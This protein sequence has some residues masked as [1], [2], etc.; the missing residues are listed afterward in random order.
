MSDKKIILIDMHN[1]LVDE[2]KEYGPALDAA[3]DAFIAAARKNNSLPADFD[4]EKFKNDQ[5][6]PE[7]KAAHAALSD[8]WDN[9]AFDKEHA[10]ALRALFADD[11]AYEAAK[12]DAI[13]ARTE[14]SKNYISANAYPGAINFIKRARMDGH[15]VYVVTDGNAV[16]AEATLAWLGLD[17]E[18]DGVFCPPSDKAAYMGTPR[19]TQTPVVHFAPG[20]FKPD[21]SIV[22]DILLYHAKNIGLVPTTLSRDEAF[23]LEENTMLPAEASSSLKNR[24]NIK[25]GAHEPTI[26]HLLQNTIG[27]G[28]DYRDHILFQNAGVTSVAADYGKPAE[29]PETTR[30]KAIMKAVSGW[31]PERLDLL[32]AVGGKP[33]LEKAV[34]PDY[35][36]KE[37]LLEA[38]ILL[39]GMPAVK[40]AVGVAH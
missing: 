5:A 21:A 38:S 26:Q 13:H 4:A 15:T 27:I 32:G 2:V 24:L 35:R 14:F 37:S 7:L 1:T 40:A 25:S 33:W 23:A 6:Y 34:N 20:Q 30:G 39:T 8:D 29:D 17:G 19:L 18:V 12:K 16:A 22:A 31:A 9:R 3:V 10:P 28:D 11:A 36:C